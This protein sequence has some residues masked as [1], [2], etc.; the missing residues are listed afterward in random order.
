MKKVIVAILF[1]TLNTLMFSQE[2]K[3]IETSKLVINS[4]QK[5][6]FSKIIECFD[7]TMKSALPVEKLKLVWDDLNSKCGNFQKLRKE[8]FRI[9]M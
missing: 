4:F 5:K 1:C 9:I 6:E 8:K 7:Q 3:N 2:N